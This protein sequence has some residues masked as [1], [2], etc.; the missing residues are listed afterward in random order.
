MI[1]SISFVKPDKGFPFS[2][3]DAM[4]LILLRRSGS[5][6]T[7]TLSISGSISL[8]RFSTDFFMASVNSPL[9]R[10]EELRVGK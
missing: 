6:V 10:S 9:Y 3:S 7:T 1:S 5:A 8:T 2:I 4:V